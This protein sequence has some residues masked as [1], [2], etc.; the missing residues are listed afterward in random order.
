MSED[1]NGWDEWKNH[2][3]QELKALSEGQKEQSKEINN[4][5]IDIA[6][7]K[8]KSSLWGAITG[9]IASVVV[10]VGSVLIGK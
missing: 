6:T 8:T 2:V 5:R 10:A 3:L 9:F 1:T 7:L 4:C